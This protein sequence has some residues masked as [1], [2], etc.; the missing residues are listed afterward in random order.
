MEP[1]IS[2]IVP[3]YNVE[4]YVEE[5]IESILNQTLKNIEIIIVNDG[6]TDKSN[7]LVNNLA[8]KDNRITVI[9]QSNKG[10]SMARNVG[11]DLAKGEYVSFIDSDDWIEKSMLEEMY[12]SA[13]N[14]NCDIVQCQ[15]KN[16]KNNIPTR[17]LLDK[18]DI[19]KYIKRQLIAGKLSTYAWDKI[20]KRK[21]LKDNNLYFENKPRFEDWYFIMKAVSKMS[22]FMAI[23]NQFYNYRTNEGSLSK[24]YYNNYEDLIIELQEK[25]Y[26]YMKAWEISSKE[27]ELKSLL[28][29][30]DDILHLINYIY[31]PQYGLSKKEKLEKL[32]KISVN[33]F[34]RKNFLTYKY[35]MYIEERNINKVYGKIIYN[36]LYYKNV[37]LI[38]II[39]SLYYLKT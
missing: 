16:I 3:V 18:S 26:E 30:G 39:K 4:K 25:K 13:K 35:K 5:C 34:I 19:K 22:R 10:L 11:V 37:R 28:N 15:I 2:V 7:E 27:D 33:K 9:N 32:K 12:K 6:S 8:N 24:R 1:L 31:N 36:G 29:L 17:K 20:Y 14:N 38:H 21:F 23:D